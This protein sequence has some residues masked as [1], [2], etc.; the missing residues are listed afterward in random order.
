MS[1]FANCGRADAH[2][3]ASYV[4]TEVGMTSFVTCIADCDDVSMISPA[5]SAKNRQLGQAPAQFLVLSPEFLRVARVEFG[6]HIKLR[7]TFRRCIG[8]KPADPFGPAGLTQEH[9]IKM[10]GMGAVAPV[11]CSTVLERVA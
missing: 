1:A 5:A 8:S 9:T 3:R 11:A 10:G 2:V 4:P 7:V 6:R